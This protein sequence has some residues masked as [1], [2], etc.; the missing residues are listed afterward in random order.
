MLRLNGYIPV[1]PPLRG[2]WVAVNTPAERVPS[3][4]TDYF[5][6]TY[7]FDFAKLDRTG[8]GFSSRPLWQQFLLAIPAR[9]FL[10]WSEPVYSSFGGVVVDVAGDWP[11]RRHVNALW[12]I[13]RAHLLT[14]RPSSTDFRPLLG[15]YLMVE[16]EPGIAL[17]AH[18]LQGSVGPKRGSLVER[19]QLI[20]RVGNSGNSTMPHLHFHVMDDADPRVAKGVPVALRNCGVKRGDALEVQEAGVPEVMVP[21]VA[22]A[23]PGAGE[24]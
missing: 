21:F 11:D 14:K 4:G 23:P 16:G 18:L 9:S 7:A 6:Q 12:Q 22:L 13:L 10:A 1:D 19:G 17:Y 20:G 2:E 3:H 5:G 24:A 15:N 8:A